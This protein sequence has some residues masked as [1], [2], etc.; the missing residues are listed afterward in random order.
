MLLINNTLD[1]KKSGQ[2]F[3][4]LELSTLVEQNGG[5]SNFFDDDLKLLYLI[6]LRFR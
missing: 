2:N 1:N 3:Q 4:N 5:K 6:F